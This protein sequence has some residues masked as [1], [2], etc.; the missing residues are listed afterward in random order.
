MERTSEVPLEL[1]LLVQG[2]HIHS[3]NLHNCFRCYIAELA[4]RIS[5]KLALPSVDRELELKHCINVGEICGSHGACYEDYFLKE[6]E[7]IKSCRQTQILRSTYRTL[8][9][10][11]IFKD[12]NFHNIN[13]VR[14][15]AITDF[16]PSITHNIHNKYHPDHFY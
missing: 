9:L 7:A 11:M 13:R 12:R 6:Y 16:L 3:Q 4:W 15:A 1:E 2:L 8:L 10:C 5:R 14:K